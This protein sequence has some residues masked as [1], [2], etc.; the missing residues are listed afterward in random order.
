PHHETAHKSY[1]GP[2]VSPS[3]C[4]GP[5]CKLHSGE[6]YFAFPSSRG[7]RRYSLPVPAFRPQAQ[8]GNI[9]SEILE[10][11]PYARSIEA[12]VDDAKEASDYSQANDT[13]STARPMMCFR[14]WG[15]VEKKQ[16]NGSS[17]CSVEESKEV[18]TKG[19]AGVV[20]SRLVKK[21]RKLTAVVLLKRLAMQ[22]KKSVVAL[23]IRRF[24][25]TQSTT[26][27]IEVPSSKVVQLVSL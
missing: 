18:N 24:D 26:R 8:A 27:K 22:V 3:P 12:S 20:R 9:E 14:D 10:H 15:T 7:G 6:D 21:V 4:S 1:C 19:N 25:D 23:L 11:I 5:H 17:F 16:E 13:S 2:S